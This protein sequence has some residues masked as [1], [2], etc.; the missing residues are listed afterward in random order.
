MGDHAAAL[1]QHLQRH[2][3]VGPGGRA[4]QHTPEEQQVAIV[5]GMVPLKA[6]G[7]AKVC[8][9]R[10]GYG[11]RLGKFRRVQTREA[12][13]RKLMKARARTLFAPGQF[14][15]RSHNAVGAHHLVL[16]ANQPR[17]RLLR[18][19]CAQRRGRGGKVKHRVDVKHINIRQA[20]GGHV[21]RIVGPDRP[22][23]TT[24]ENHPFRRVNARAQELRNLAPLRFGEVGVK[25]PVARCQRKREHEQK[26]SRERCHTPGNALARR[27]IIQQPCPNQN[28]PR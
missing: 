13:Q 2:L 22:R 14:Q 27:Q 18:R 7:V 5:E 19:A 16:P 10:H 23:M 28:E 6:H 3:I 20:H 15:L 17:T 8:A 26:D 25:E 1:I 24:H 4:L 11:W 21:G 9:H 12:A